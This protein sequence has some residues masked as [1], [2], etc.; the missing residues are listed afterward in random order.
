MITHSRGA[1]LVPVPL[2]LQKHA[3]REA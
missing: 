1:P 2:R 3:G